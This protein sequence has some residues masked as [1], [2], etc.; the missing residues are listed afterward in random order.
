ML[1]VTG[2]VDVTGLTNLLTAGG[3]ANVS[4]Y[5][6][7]TY[8]QAGI[9]SDYQGGWWNAEGIQ[10]PATPEQLKAMNAGTDPLTQAGKVV[11]PFAIGTG[12]SSIQQFYRLENEASGGSMF[13]GS[14]F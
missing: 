7:A 6:R 13:G 10:G 3:Q 12:E 8:D 1:G 2:N 4:S 5:L 11:S 9:T 14:A